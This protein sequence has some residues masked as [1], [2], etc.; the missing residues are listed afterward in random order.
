MSFYSSYNKRKR[1]RETKKLVSSFFGCCQKDIT[2]I[3][4]LLLRCVSYRSVPS[5]QTREVAVADFNNTFQAEGVYRKTKQLLLLLLL[6]LRRRRPSL[7]NVNRRRE[8]EEDRN[9][10]KVGPPFGPGL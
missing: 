1:E 5:R 2:W 6:L 8:K 3:R 9:E 7:S 10:K 4:N